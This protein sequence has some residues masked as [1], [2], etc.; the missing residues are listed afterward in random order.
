MRSDAVTR[1]AAPF[2]SRTPTSVPATLPF[3]PAPPAVP[4]D[5]RS[6]ELSALRETVASLDAQARAW[7]ASVERLGGRTV[8]EAADA[9]AS[10]EAQLEALYAEVDAGAPGAA[11]R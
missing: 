9:L 2:T 3:S 6:A 7:Y 1:L 8:D 5:E 11:P 4:D 10:Y